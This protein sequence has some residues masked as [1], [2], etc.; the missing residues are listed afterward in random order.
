[1][2]PGS[3]HIDLV[4]LTRSTLE[5]GKAAARCHV[6]SG[7]PPSQRSLPSF[8]TLAKATHNRPRTTLVLFR[9]SAIMGAGLIPVRTFTLYSQR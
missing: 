3:F 1:M 9:K 2:C 4:G 7:S 6:R 8:W 5:K